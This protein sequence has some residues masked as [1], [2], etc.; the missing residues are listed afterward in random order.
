MQI[1]KKLFV[2]GNW[3]CNNTIK[4]SRQILDTIVSKLKFNQEKVDVAIF[5]TTLHLMDV[6]HNNQNKNVIV[7]SQNVSKFGFGA[8]TGETSHLHLNDLGINWTLI[9][10]S[11][12]R[13]LFGESNEIVGLKTKLALENKMKVVL[14]IG[15]SLSE[16]EANKTLDIIGQQLND[17]DTKI[18]DKTAWKDI[19]IAYEPVWAIGTGKVASPEQAQD[20]HKWIR[21]WLKL[22]LG[23]EGSNAA[24]IIYGGSVTEKNC[25][26]LIEQPDIDGFLV[27]GASLKPAFLDIV[28]SVDKAAE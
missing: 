23:D 9:G 21:K 14:C 11:E 24:R 8:Y 2:G 17:V 5:P 20:V 16:R 22:S 28:S 4:E 6:I 15:E 12:R 10:H 18:T 19:V 13:A 7:G 1:A 27:G 3:K 25:K 26:E